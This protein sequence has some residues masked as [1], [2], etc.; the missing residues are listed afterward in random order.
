MNSS[1]FG[2]FEAS[3]R[4]ALSYKNTKRGFVAHKNWNRTVG[5]G[6]MLTNLHDLQQWDQ[7]FYQPESIAMVLLEPG[8]LVNGN[9]LTYGRGIMTAKYRNEIIHFHPGA[10]LGYR[11]EILRFPARQITIILLGNSEGTDPERITRQIADAY[12]FNDV[13]PKEKVTHIISAQQTKNLSSLIGRYEVSNNLFIDISLADRQFWGQLSGQPRK[14]LYPIKNRIFIIEN[15][16][17]SLFFNTDSTNN[18][19]NLLVVQK[20]GKTLAVR[21]NYVSGEAQRQFGG[22]YYSSEQ[23]VYYK[24]SIAKGSL[25]LNVGARPREIVK[26]LEKYESA[27]LNYQDLEKAAI[28]FR[29]AQN[30]TI[31]GFTLSSGRIAELE[32]RKIK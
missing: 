26:V 18:I 4:L 17:D 6:G 31:T 22:T 27:N 16:T 7:E 3:C 8:K 25:Y 14:K 10:F 13:F 24:F 1:S 9:L 29:R 11:S 32:F 23:K 28:K 15:S 19:S 2:S 5:D 30:G 20:Q 12:V 21:L